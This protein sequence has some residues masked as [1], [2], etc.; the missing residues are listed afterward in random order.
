MAIRRDKFRVTPE[1]QLDAVMALADQRQLAG[2]RVR[3][4]PEAIDLPYVP[5]L[6][7]VQ[8]ATT[9][10]VETGLKRPFPEA[11]LEDWVR[12]AQSCSKDTRILYCSRFELS[13]TR[14]S[15]LRKNRIGL[16]VVSGDEIVDSILPHD[17]AMKL[18]LPPMS[19]I[20]APLRRKLSVAYQK[21]S[22]GEWKGAFEEF[23][24]V[25]EVAS[26]NYLTKHCRSTRIQVVHQSNGR[27][28]V[29]TTQQINKMPIGA[30]ANHFDRIYQKN[31]LDSQIGA[32]LIAINSDRVAVAHKKRGAENR[33]RK[34]V[35]SHT[36]AIINCLKKMY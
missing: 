30:L 11:R 7:L 15:W 35:G 26:R 19:K 4:E 21:H 3:P 14:E 27:L 12:Y 31:V 33:L 16:A 13:R 34:N 18:E 5:A 9:I 29:P 6:E 8:D 10:Y 20:R 25:F 2:Y 1:E 36:W 28:S 32:T 24:K 22:Q 17:L 23:C